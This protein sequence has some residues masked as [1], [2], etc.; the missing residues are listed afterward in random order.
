[1]IRKNKGLSL[2]KSH[3]MNTTIVLFLMS[4]PMLLNLFIFNYI[5]MAGI[6]VAFKN[7][8]YAKGMFHSDWVGLKNF[9]LFFINPDSFRI[10]RNTIG[11][12]LIFLTVGLACNVAIALLLNEI[13]S[14]KAL[15]VY[16]TIMFF[17]YFMSWVVVAYIVYALLNTRMGIINGLFNINVD[18]YNTSDAWPAIIVI[19]NIWKNIGYGSIIYYAAIIGIDTSYYEAAKIEGASRLQM[20]FKIT[21]PELYPLMVIMTILG[22]GAIFS[23]DFGLF[24]QLT[25]DSKMLYPTT[26]VL[27]TYVFRALMKDGNIGI[28]SA[29][30]V[31]KSIVGFVL[32]VLTNYCVKKYDNDYALY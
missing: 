10:F 20:V 25:M 22:I 4:L 6:V 5:P 24:Y 26:D 31:F 21:L 11:Y 27:D 7:F 28:S 1:M 15:K 13:R 30:G 17:P 3:K 16:Q 12:N 14:K 23:S 32:V 9:R 19:S 29:A 2:T 8:S 18:W